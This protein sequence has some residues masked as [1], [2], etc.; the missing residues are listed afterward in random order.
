MTLPGGLEPCGGQ[1]FKDQRDIFLGLRI[2][3]RVCLNN[4]EV[5]AQ[6]VT[7]EQ[8]LSGI[9]M[10]GNEPVATMPSTKPQFISENSEG[11]DKK[12]EFF[13]SRADEGEPVGKLATVRKT[14]LTSQRWLENEWLWGIHA[15][16]QKP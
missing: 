12:R 16:T 5:I 1:E 15:N 10:Y 7:G 9:I 2:K 4:S 11:I 6:P 13:N 3:K 14:P 8:L